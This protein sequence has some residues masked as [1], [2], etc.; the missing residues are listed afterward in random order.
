MAEAVTVTFSGHTIAVRAGGAGVTLTVSGA[1]ALVANF[2]AAGPLEVAV[3]RGAP[4]A[5]ADRYFL[6]E[7]DAVG[8]AIMARFWDV[9][10]K[11]SWGYREIKYDLDR[12]R[13][14]HI[15]QAFRDKYKDILGFFVVGD[16]VV[17][18]Q[19][20]RFKSRARFPAERA[21]LKLQDMNEEDHRLTYRELFLVVPREERAAVRGAADALECVAQ[22]VR[23]VEEF[24]DAAD[25]I[26]RAEWYFAACLA[27]GI[28]FS[29]LFAFV[30]LFRKY[31]D[32][33][34]LVS[35]N[36]FI[37]RDETLHR[38]FNAHMCRVYGGVAPERAAALARQAV[39]VEE[40]HVRHML[41][42]PF[43]TGAPPG[44]WTD[45]ALAEAVARDAAADISFERL[46]AYVQNMANQCLHLA[47][48]APLY[49]AAPGLPWMEDIGLSD[50]PNFYERKSD[51]YQHAVHGD[52]GD[53]PD[54]F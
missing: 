12:R 34:A 20:D 7:E 37:M 21:F 49:P 3:A 33:P 16:G 1:C 40:A 27:E 23:F 42:A 18:E 6:D 29:S 52:A 24:I 30:F 54:V 17:C 19:V 36:K 44:G 31:C 39:A 47:G 53:D 9:A 2:A 45:A 10:K 8:G 41:R 38:D 28:F 14:A 43:L 48:H 4:D 13:W 25:R 22:K 51:N 26:P 50:K 35:A 15:P 32:M 46:Q 5:L 11:Q